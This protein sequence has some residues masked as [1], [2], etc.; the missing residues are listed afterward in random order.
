MG[1]D[2]DDNLTDDQLLEMPTEALPGDLSRLWTARAAAVHNPEFNDLV[3]ELTGASKSHLMIFRDQDPRVKRQREEEAQWRAA[4]EIQDYFER[5]DR[6]L[7]R[8]DEQ[9]RFIAKR[10]QEIEDNALK[11]HDGRRVYVD[12][13]QYR[14]EN[15]NILSGSARDE[16]AEL[17][18]GNPQASTWQQKKD[19]DDRYAEA[20]R[21]RQ[22]VLADRDA[23]GRGGDISA[24]NDKLT[25]DEKEFTAQVEARAAQSPTDYG[26]SDYMAA[27]GDD[28]QMSTVPAFTKA[29]AV[30]G[31]TIAQA[32]DTETESTTA[33]AKKAPQPL[34]Q[35]AL[36]LG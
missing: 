11:L 1:N 12:G 35:G 9:E 14:D 33:D 18:R 21:L 4:R 6:L 19:I 30:T 26:S 27:Y 20:E 24:A 2:D 22:K 34:G 31:E 16:A 17:H 15:G 36:K 8:I 29:A 25:A 23:A 13:N 5:S 3:A 7:A 32:S 10:R 28:Y